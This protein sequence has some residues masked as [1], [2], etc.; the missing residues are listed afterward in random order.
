MLAVIIIIIFCLNIG[1]AATGPAGLALTPLQKDGIGLSII[2][3]ISDHM[4]YDTEWKGV[5]RKTMG[6]SLLALGNSIGKVAG[7]QILESC[8]TCVL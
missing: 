2:A 8:F 6:V 3:Q 7:L 4:L 5:V 1:Q